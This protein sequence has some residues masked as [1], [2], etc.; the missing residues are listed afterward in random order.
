MSNSLLLN[1]LKIFAVLAGL[2]GVVQ[3]MTGF[4]WVELPMAHGRLAETGF[5]ILIIASV[6]AWM[7]S[8]RSG[9]K[10]LFMHSIGMA[11]IALLQI[12]LGHM[13]MRSVHIGVGVLFLVGVLALATLSFRANESQISEPIDRSRLQG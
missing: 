4:G 1:L 11:V 10:G 6:F 13:D 3:M 2:S 9:E 7:W 5:V 8:R 12:A